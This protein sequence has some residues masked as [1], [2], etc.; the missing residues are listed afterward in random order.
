MHEPLCLYSLFPEL[1]PCHRNAFRTDITDATISLGASTID[2]AAPDGHLSYA[3]VVAC[4]STIKATTPN[5]Y[6]RIC[7][8]HVKRDISY[9]GSNSIVPADCQLLMLSDRNR[10]WHRFHITWKCSDFVGRSK[11]QYV[12]HVRMSLYLMLVCCQ[13]ITVKKWNEIWIEIANFS[14]NNVDLN[15]SATNVCYFV[16]ASMSY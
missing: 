12:G 10:E 4:V 3:L 14:F 13:L 1:S 11:I 9:S 2:L 5:V 15:I 6:V 8:F 16:S 7:I